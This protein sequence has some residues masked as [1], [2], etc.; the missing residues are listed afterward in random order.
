MVTTTKRGVRIVEHM[1]GVNKVAEEVE[2]FERRW[3]RAW[4]ASTT[5]ERVRQLRYRDNALPG[6][7]PEPDAM[8]PFGRTV[9]QVTAAVRK[10]LLG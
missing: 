9:A 8:S 5:P 10:A 3:R 4:I 6:P 7:D 1:L 2:A